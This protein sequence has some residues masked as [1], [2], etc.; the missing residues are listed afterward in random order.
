MNEKCKYC[1][2]VSKCSRICEYNSVVCKLHRSFPKIVD[3]SYEQLQQENQELKLE[4]S[5][6]RQA[7]LKDKEMLGLKEENQK[8]KEVIDKAINDLNIII[9]IVRE[10]PLGSDC[11]IIDRLEAN[12]SILKEV[13]K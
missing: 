12:K 3:K 7:I 13:S 10:L 9:D 1:D 11:W 2:Y 8:Y 6:Y 5:G 4:L